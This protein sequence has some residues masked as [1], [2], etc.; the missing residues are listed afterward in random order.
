MLL[1]T[2]AQDLARLN[3]VNKALYA[4]IEDNE[5]KHLWK[6][7]YL[8]FFDHPKYAVEQIALEQPSHAAGENDKYLYNWRTALKRRV[9]ASKIIHGFQNANRTDRILA[10]RTL[11]DIVL[12]APPHAPD[13]IHSKSAQFVQDL[14]DQ[15][16]L[17]AFNKWPERATAEELELKAWL[18]ANRATPPAEA[19]TFNKDFDRLTARATIYD[20]ENHRRH[21][22]FGPFTAGVNISWIYVDAIIQV[23]LYNV[24]QDMDAFDLYPPSTFQNSRRF[25]AKDY[26]RRRPHDWAGIDGVWTRLVCFCDFRYLAIAKI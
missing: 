16:P 10:L 12:S 4:L 6:N 21:E 26:H 9:R 8:R 3:L 22:Q 2:V 1:I 5:D 11:C 18:R 17:P 20:L 25:S 23:A 13:R 14:L 19:D 15:S 7:V 24:K